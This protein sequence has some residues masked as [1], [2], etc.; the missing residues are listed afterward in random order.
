MRW[1]RTRFRSRSC[2]DVRFGVLAAALVLAHSGA[3]AGDASHG[4][5]VYG[6]C[7]ACH[8]LAYDRV[9]PRHCDLL[10]R[11]AGSVEGFEYSD[12]MRRSGIVWNAGMLDRFLADPVRVVPGTTMTY[13][14][15]EKRQDR[16]DLIAFL[17]LARCPVSP[18]M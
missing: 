12:A 5:Q 13:A 7:A 18:R 11:R 4:E 14:G 16:A 10:G 2:P 1:A 17:A 15:I 6:R 9:G 8:A 3:A